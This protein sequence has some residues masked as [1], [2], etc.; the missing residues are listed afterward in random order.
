[1][2]F[3]PGFIAYLGFM[4]LPILLSFYFSF[5]DWD[6][7]S[8]TM[9]F[10]GLRNFSRAIQDESFLNALRVTVAPPDRW[11]PTMA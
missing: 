5:F 2:L 6:G 4:I 3:T 11:T 10:V 7:F 8:R 9:S 1:M